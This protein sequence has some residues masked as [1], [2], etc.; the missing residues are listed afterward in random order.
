MKR[1]V[2]GRPSLDRA[3]GSTPIL[4]K[5]PSPVYDRLYSTAA[6]AGIT[7]PEL[8]RRLIAANLDIQNCQPAGR[9][10]TLELDLTR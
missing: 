5:V 9:S 3:H 7:V 10:A 4:L 6:R 2:R 1:A 8:V